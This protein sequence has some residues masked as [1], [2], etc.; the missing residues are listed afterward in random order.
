MKSGIISAGGKLYLRLGDKAIPF[1]KFDANGKP[2]IK[3]E[4]QRV[5]EDGKVNVIVKI[6]TYLVYVSLNY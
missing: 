1:D 5:E 3:V 4:T 2:I 6:P